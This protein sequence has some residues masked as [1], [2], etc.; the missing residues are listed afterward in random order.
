M[1]PPWGTGEIFLRNHCILAHSGCGKIAFYADFMRFLVR[2]P[3]KTGQKRSF[4]GPRCSNLG[5]LGSEPA[6][7][8][9]FAGARLE[10]EEHQQS[11]FAK[12]R[13]CFLLGRQQAG[14]LARDIRAPDQEKLPSRGFQWSAPRTISVIRMTASSTTTA[15]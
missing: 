11:S 13:N 7:R 5:R 2:Y 10:N 8:A 14:P 15:S 12:R 6:W 3:L 9:A 4:F 1:S